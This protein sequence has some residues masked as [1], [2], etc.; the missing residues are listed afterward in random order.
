MAF[1]ERRS[2]ERSTRYLTELLHYC[3]RLRE[4][5]VMIM[6]DIIHLNRYRRAVYDSVKYHLV[7]RNCVAVHPGCSCMVG[8]TIEV[9]ASASVPYFRVQ[10]PPLLNAGD[11]QQ[12]RGLQ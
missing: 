10:L 4:T 5:T 9:A 1:R 3:W 8:V 12:R 7:H 11:V 6:F 2:L